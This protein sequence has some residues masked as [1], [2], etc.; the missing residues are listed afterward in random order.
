M[1]KDFVLAVRH[2]LKPNQIA[3]NGRTLGAPERAF[4]SNG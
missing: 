1:K 2:V 3:S 4:A